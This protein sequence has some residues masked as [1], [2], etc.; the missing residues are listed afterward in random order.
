[1]PLAAR[2]LRYFAFA[3]AAGGLLAARPLHAASDM[4]VY[5]VTVPVADRSAAT[6]DSGFQ[7]AMKIV[8]VRA[9]GKLSAG[10]DAVLAPLVDGATRYVQEYRYAPDGRLW[11]E[12]DGA[13][14]ERWLVAN[15][16]PVWGRTRPTTFVWL[17]VQGGPQTGSVVT[18][19]DTSDLKAQIDAQA[20]LRGIELLWPS[21]QQLQDNRLDYNAVVRAAPAALQTLA[22][23]LGGDGV[24]IGHASAGAAPSGAAPAVQWLQ[25]FQDRSGAV[26]G[27][28][29][30]VN[31]AADTYAAVFAVSGG[32]SPVDVE[33]GGIGNVGDYAR[34]QH[35]LASLTIVSGVTVLGLHG[36]AI[37]FRLDVRGGAT[38]LARTLALNGPL[39]ADTPAAAGDN[40]RFHLRR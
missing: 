20:D 1:M 24:L 26:A 4:N 9:T 19:G 28:A 33:I 7:A 35:Y 23:R 36:D 12:F 11:A 40:L 18:G 30:G 17:T 13:A 21:A 32:V 38:P 8:L 5:Q 29:D 22:N 16:E 37:A 27:A 39:A 31:L 6:R 25:L 34:V 3:C 15:G 10:A 14:I 2:T